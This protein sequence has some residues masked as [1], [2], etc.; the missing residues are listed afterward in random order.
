ML[1]LYNIEERGMTLKLFKLIILYIHIHTYIYVFMY[2]CMYFALKLFKLIILYTH[3]YITCMLA[4]TY[5][6]ILE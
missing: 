1:Y 5:V 2:V 6:C 3:I 4:Y